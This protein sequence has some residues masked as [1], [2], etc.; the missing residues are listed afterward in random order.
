M[1]H[2]VRSRLIRCGTVAASL[3]FFFFC[4]PLF[5][6]ETMYIP[7]QR[8][9]VPEIAALQMYDVLFKQYTEDRALA[10]KQI[11]NQ[12]PASLGFYCY[13][14]KKDDILLTLSARF[15]IPIETL[16]TANG[17][18]FPDTAITGK[19]L[20]I[21][22]VPGLFLPEEAE[23]AFEL[24]LQKSHSPSDD[25]P[26]Y[27]IDGRA[28]V[29]LQNSRMNP[30]ER[31]FFLDTNLCMPLQK[32]VL[33]S[34]F[35]YRVSP[36]SGAWKFHSGVDLA[37]PLGSTV[38]ACKTGTVTAAVKNDPIFGNYIIVSH[39]GEMTSVYAHLS[40]MTVK[41]GDAVGAGAKI[42]EVG[43]TGASTGPHLHFEIRIHG[44][45]TDPGSVLSVD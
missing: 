10:S 41:K 8:E 29:F 17:I 19:K 7:V 45:P 18:A 20:L 3:F 39:F 22:T 23:N 34:A 12:K 30:T 2:S 14:A 16:A 26:R 4:T 1:T 11:A 31:A 43:S 6:A 32:H 33:S 25:A 37:A 13:T 38:F 40:K 9:Y 21:P 15:T 27:R 44:K 28:Y 24:I 5:Y 42:G 36:I 35:G